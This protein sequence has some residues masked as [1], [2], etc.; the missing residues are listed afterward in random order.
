MY[1]LPEIYSETKLLSELIHSQYS[2][3]CSLN[4]F[5]EAEELTFNLYKW[6]PASQFLRH[7]PLGKIVS[8]N[9][10]LYFLAIH[11]FAMSHIS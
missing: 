5:V 4:V 10:D 7:Y 3:Y 8:P 9:M 6:S 1:S 2:M 11:R